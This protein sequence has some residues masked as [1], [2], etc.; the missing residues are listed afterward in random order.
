LGVT[1]LNIGL[2]KVNLDFF[3]ALALGVL[4]NALVCLAVWLCF[5]A[6]ST[7]DKIA[8]IIFP[9]TAFVAAGFEHCVANMYFIPVAILIKTG[10]PDAFWQAV[11][12][13]PAAYSD[14][15]WGSFLLNN[16]LPVTLGNIIG[17]VFFVAVV[18]WLVY[19]RG[20]VSI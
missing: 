16:L 10:A 4:C 17:G 11:G 20:K 18:Y 7:L 12:K 19:L 5:S 6:R 14:I 13:N 2:A 8:A 3:P 15:T 1:A 9:I